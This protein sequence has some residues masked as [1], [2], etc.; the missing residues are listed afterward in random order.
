MFTRISL[1]SKCLKKNLF[2]TLFFQVLGTYLVIYKGVNIKR[3]L[4]KSKEYGPKVVLVTF[5]TRFVTINLYRF[6]IFLTSLSVITLIHQQLKKY[7][8]FYSAEKKQTPLYFLLPRKAS[9]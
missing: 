3:S 8:M 2:F 6:L 7:S 4:V 5:V 1:F 9:P